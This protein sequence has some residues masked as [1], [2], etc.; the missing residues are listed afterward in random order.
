MRDLGRTRSG[1]IDNLSDRSCGQTPR[2]TISNERGE[3]EL[4]GATDSLSSNR[5]SPRVLGAS[6][7]GP[8]FHDITSPIK[9]FPRLSPFLASLHTPH[10]D[11]NRLRLWKFLAHPHASSTVVTHIVCPRRTTHT[12]SHH[13]FRPVHSPPRRS[14]SARHVV[15]TVLNTTTDGGRLVELQSPLFRLQIHLRKVGSNHRSQRYILSPFFLRLHRL[16]VRFAMRPW[17]S[18]WQAYL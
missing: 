6:Q 13:S 16:M 17:T 15:T 18:G 8:A 7:G 9:C 14:P 3:S 2:W 4:G 1:F 10:R 11:S 12:I 5:S